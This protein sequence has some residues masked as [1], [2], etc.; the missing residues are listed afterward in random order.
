M[1]F[2][3]DLKPKKILSIKKVYYMG[4]SILMETNQIID[5]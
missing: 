3:K 5:K 4:N 1:D 2:K